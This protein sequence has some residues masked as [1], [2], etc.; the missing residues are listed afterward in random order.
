MKLLRRSK[1]QE[2]IEIPGLILPLPD[3][4]PVRQFPASFIDNMR[5]MI[6]RVE[7][8]E[9]IPQRLAVVSALRAEGVSHICLALATTLAHDTT[10]KVCVVDLN[11][12]W[13]SNV[14]DDENPGLAGV[15]SGEASLEEVITPSGWSNLAFVSAGNVQQGLRPVMARSSILKDILEELSQKYDH[16]ILDIPAIL[17]TSD[18]IPLASLADACCVVVQHGITTTEDISSA[19]DE[20]AHMKI[21]GVIMNRVKLSTPEKILKYI[22]I[23]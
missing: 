7:R 3:G 17:A 14:V 13:P 1:K 21:L 2:T 16:L 9:T 12:W 19:L 18:A 15:I 6:N 5:A 23:K 4:T 22:P 10:K 20:V 11:W 8:N